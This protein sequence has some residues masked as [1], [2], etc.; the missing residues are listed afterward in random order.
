MRCRYNSKI[1]VI[2][3][4]SEF[5]T[6]VRISVTVCNKIWLPERNPPP[7]KA[8]PLSRGQR[9]WNVPFIKGSK[10]LERPL[11]KGE[12]VCEANEGDLRRRNNNMIYM[13][14][15]LLAPNVPLTVILRAKN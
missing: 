8:T 6:G 15:M 9:L 12:N 1:D 5:P 14:I 11:D 4:H 10:T 13:T 2:V 3:C 7:K